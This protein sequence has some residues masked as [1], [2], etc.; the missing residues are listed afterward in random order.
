[1]THTP[2]ELRRLLAEHGLRLNKRLGQHYLI[3]PHLTRR[4]IDSCH[5]RAEETIIEIGAGLGALTGLLA[6]RVK[7]VIA[8]EVDPQICR[9]L[10]QRLKPFANVHVCCQDILTFPWSDYPGSKVVGAIPYLLTSRIL[11]GLCE[12]A[13]RMPEAWLSVQQEVADRLTARPGSKA[14]GRLT[15]L[16]QYRF[17]VQALV[18]MSPHAFFPPPDVASTWIHLRAHAQPPVALADESWFFEVVK[19]AFAQRRKTLANCLQRLESVRLSRSQTSQ[20]LQDLG[21]SD[22][23][24]GE[25][26][27]LEQF[28]RLTERLRPFAPR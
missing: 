19:A 7:Q 17:A 16:V 8:V 12:Q 23:V 2:S 6:K 28:A 5:L 4:L 11:V 18:R 26:L 9:I 3:D 20:I 22:R 13:V 25:T 10:A 1:M 15:V 21:L 24:R 14:Y 27:S